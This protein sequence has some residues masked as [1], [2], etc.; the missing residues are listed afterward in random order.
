MTYILQKK[1]GAYGSGQLI[2][3]SFEITATDRDLI[4]QMENHKNDATEFYKRYNQLSRKDL[5]MT[6]WNFSQFY[7]KPQ[8]KPQ[9]KPQ[10]KT[11]LPALQNKKRMNFSRFDYKHQTQQHLDSLHSK[12]ST[13][14]AAAMPLPSVASKYKLT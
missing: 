5:N 9:N 2:I 6:T 12:Q 11:Q 8:N 1:I 3:K 10:K 13:N 14:K 7:F 4:V